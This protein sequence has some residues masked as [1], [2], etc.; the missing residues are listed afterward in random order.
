MQTL[1]LDIKL[2]SGRHL[3]CPIVLSA[4]REL[5][6]C[7]VDLTTLICWVTPKKSFLYPLV[8][9]SGDLVEMMLKLMGELTKDRPYDLIDVAADDVKVIIKVK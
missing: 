9:T 3:R 2:K 7:A 6:D 5:M 8:H 4:F 1:W